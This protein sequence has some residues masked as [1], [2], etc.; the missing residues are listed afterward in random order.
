MSV[1]SSK[2]GLSTM[3]WYAAH[4]ITWPLLLRLLYILFATGTWWRVNMIHLMHGFVLWCLNHW[5]TFWILH[6]YLDICPVT[7][8]T[9]I[10]AVYCTVLSLATLVFKP[11]AWFSSSWRNWSGCLATNPAYVKFR[12]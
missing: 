8:G 7:Y 5:R 12:M 9:Q 3:N 6:Y 1:I 2:G 11:P 10:F 4:Q